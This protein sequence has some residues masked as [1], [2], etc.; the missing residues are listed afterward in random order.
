MFRI[1]PTFWISFKIVKFAVCSKIKDVCVKSSINRQN[2][3]QMY[4]LFIDIFLSSQDEERLIRVAIYMRNII[5]DESVPELHLAWSDMSLA[6]CV[7]VCFFN[8][9]NS[10]MH[11]IILCQRK[12]IKMLII[13]MTY[14]AKWNYFRLWVANDPDERSLTKNKSLATTCNS[15]KVDFI[16]VCIYTCIEWMHSISIRKTDIP[17][18]T[19]SNR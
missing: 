15:T 11:V 13:M 12:R 14:S 8:R 7:Y 19:P 3:L 2:S 5:P 1:S 9:I 18:S 17:D 4:F 16:H 10:S 6:S